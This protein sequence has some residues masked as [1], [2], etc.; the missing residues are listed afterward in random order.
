M[1]TVRNVQRLV[2]VYVST[3]IAFTSA[4]CPT[5]MAEEKSCTCFAYLDGAVIK[6]Q[7]PSAIGVVDK[8]KSVQTEIRELSIEDASIIEVRDC[9]KTDRSIVEREKEE[10]NK[11]NI[12]K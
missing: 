2:L 5:W 10:L 11:L 6:C 1:T 9:E 3:V 8:L 12:V 4:F 7:G